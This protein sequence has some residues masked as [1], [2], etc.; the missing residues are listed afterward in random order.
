MSILK[1]M[2]FYKN[3]KNAKRQHLEIRAEIPGVEAK[4]ARLVFTDD[5]FHTLL[6]AMKTKLGLP[7]DTPFASVLELDKYQDIVVQPASDVFDNPDEKLEFPAGCGV[8][9][10]VKEQYREQVGAE[11]LAV[12]GFTDTMIKVETHYW[13]EQTAIIPAVAKYVET[14]AVQSF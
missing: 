3:L 4:R 13:A 6:I 14:E 7:A 2:G 9:Y 12:D 5:S 11:S 8:S 1:A 10:S